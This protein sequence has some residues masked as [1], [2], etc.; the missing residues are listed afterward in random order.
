[1][2]RIPEVT[3]DDRN[4]QD[5]VNEARLRLSQRC[6][7]WSE[8]NVSDPGITLVE[9]FAWLTEAIIYRLN[10]VPEKLHVTLLNLLGIQLEPPVA[11]TTVLRF[12][13]SAPATENVEIPAGETEVGTVRTA[14]EE[15]IVFQT[16]EDFTIPPARPVY[17]AVKRGGAVKDV[18]VANGVAKP[19]GADQHA[20]GSPPKAG[21]ALYVGF[22]VP[23]ANILLELDVDCSQARGAGVDPEDPPLRWEV[24]DAEEETGWLE[25]EVVEDLTGGFN[26]GSGKVTVQLPGRHQAVPIAGHRAYWV[27]CRLDTK[28]RSGATASATY[29]HPPEIHELTA[30]P[31]G[32]VIPAAHSSRIDEEV[33]GTSDGTPGQVFDFHYYPILDPT[34]EEY[35]EVLDPGT[36]SFE[37]WEPVES[38]VESKATARHYLL[39]AAA[40]QLEFGPAIRVP[41]GSWRQYGAVPAKGATLRFNRYRHG[42]GR[43]GNVA[44]NTLTVLKSAIPGVDT[45]TNLRPAFGGVD[46]ESL[47]S[48]R[49]RAAME[50]RTRYRAVTPDDFEFLSGEASPRVA[51]AV[52]LPPGEDGMVRVHILPMVAPADRQLSLEELSPDEGLLTEVAEYLDE[53]KVIGMS[54]ELLPVKLRG[55]SVVVNVQ[56]SYNADLERVEQDVSYALYTYLNPL[57]GGSTEG[58]GDGWEFG[59]ALNQGELFGI[60][61]KIEGV[62]FIKILRVYETDL[63]T[64]KQ[65]PKPAGSYLEIGGDELV[66]SGSH[67]VKAERAELG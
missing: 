3:L 29:T 16:A 39:N 54:L 41:D 28:T 25:A 17:Y 6:P 33:L 50:I 42:G 30:A 10:R 18:G 31:I 55:V 22:D 34:P 2:A 56:A 24:S 12:R 46:A 61:R 21:D 44:A 8:H 13:L 9:L 1:M 64:G 11:A 57:V 14:N 4:F 62:D 40:G 15:A 47:E 5:L 53:R 27:C 49:T 52:C 59:R 67:I 23:L 26:Y 20:F 66:A 58:H 51:R 65:D 38:F 19:K 32:A 60:V 63:A 48:A 37:Q 35:L 43:Q 7:E 45:V 36:G